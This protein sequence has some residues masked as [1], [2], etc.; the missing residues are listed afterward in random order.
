MPTNRL[1]N[2][3]AG[4]T[5]AKDR[6]AIICGSAPCLL[7]EF[8]QVRKV[9]PDAVV[10]GINEAVWAINCHALITYHLEQKDY[11]ISK[12]LNKEI[13]VHTSKAFSSN[14]EADGFWKVKGGATSAGDSIQI[15]QQMGFDKIIL[16]GCPMNGGDGYFHDEVKENVEGCPRFGA[17][18]NVAFKHKAKLEELNKEL[19]FNNV[20]S[21]SGFTA[22]LFGKPKL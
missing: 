15:C 5:E 17:K 16:V 11:F 20:Y 6:V 2:V 3:R 14:L 8:K 18:D 1:A 13:L 21:M 22:E 4:L 10:I 19:D 12:S 7:D 9:Y